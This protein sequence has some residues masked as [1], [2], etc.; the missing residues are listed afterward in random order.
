VNRRLNATLG[1]FTV[2]V[3]V[4]I[5]TVEG[6]LALLRQRTVLATLEIQNAA[7]VAATPTPEPI[8]GS[9]A[10]PTPVSGS[11][12]LTLAPDETLVVHIH[13]MYRIGPR[14]P[15]TTIQAISQDSNG[16][17]VASGSYMILCGAETIECD[18]DQRLLLKFG[19]KDAT[20]TAAT[21]PT[22]SYT[23]VVTSSIA[24]LKPVPL[25][26]KSFA[27]AVKPAA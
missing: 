15:D 23:V 24:D 25:L 9:S 7:G 13:W 5:I 19:V 26:E 6:T 4:C 27:V 17:I 2:V 10:Q 22:G 21:W 1:C 16:Q 8:P 14:F 3:I 20:G 18:G 11:S 12:A